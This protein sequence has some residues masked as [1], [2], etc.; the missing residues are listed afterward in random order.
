MTLI[1]VNPVSVQQYGQEAQAG[2]ER[3][4]HALVTLVDEVVALRYTGPNAVTFT[5]ECGRIAADFA[6]RLHLDLSAMADAVRR[7][8]SNIA[9]ALGG[10][11]IHLRVDARPLTPPSAEVVDAVDVDTDALEDAIPAVVRHFDLLR[12]ELTRHHERL[13]ATDWDG[14]A[15]RIAV[16]SVGAFTTSA[17]RRCDAAEQSLT[18][19]IRHQVRSV[20]TAD[21]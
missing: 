5:T 12:D 21:R 13:R 4:H 3:M 8:T 6:H 2:F 16:D 15:K 20:V 19:Y 1:R 9:A 17:R 18:D 14:N 7:S 10:E 11:A